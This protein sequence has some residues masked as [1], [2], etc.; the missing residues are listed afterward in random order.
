[1]SRTSSRRLSAA[2]V[3]VA[4]LGLSLPVSAMGPEQV[5]GFLPWLQEWAASLWSAPVPD[6]PEHPAT[7]AIEMDG[8]TGSDR[9]ILIDPNGNPG[10]K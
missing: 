6:A 2:F 4:L 7:H 10:H 9:G 8:S 1:M 3:L 5:P